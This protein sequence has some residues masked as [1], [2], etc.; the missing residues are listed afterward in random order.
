VILEFLDIDEL[1][2][3]V[4]LDPSRGL[5]ILSRMSSLI[6][7][8]YDCA[9]SSI[10]VELTE[11]LPVRIDAA[12][13]KL[14][15]RNQLVQL[16]ARRIGNGS[17]DGFDYVVV[18]RSDG[19]LCLRDSD[20]EYRYEIYLAPIEQNVDIVSRCSYLITNIL[21]FSSHMSFEVRF[22]VYELLNNSLEHGVGKRADKWMQVILEKRGNK[23]LTAIVDKGVE[24][25]PT[26]ESHF[27]LGSY[28]RSGKRRGLGLILTR[29]IAERMH[30]IRESGYNKVFFEKS[31]SA[32]S[33]NPIREKEGEMAQFVIGEPKVLRDGMYLFRLEGD[34]DTKGA[35]IMED[36]MSHLLEDRRLQVT[37]DF[38]K[39]PFISSAGVGVLLGLVSSIREE[40][41][42][43][44]F[45]NL[46][47]K[48]RSVFRLLNLDDY[49]K[50]VEA[51]E[52]FMS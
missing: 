1:A 26:G 36:L 25:D 9:V 33:D 52:S 6:M 37:L 21:G 29:R 13:K 17:Q 3:R 28:L 44:S 30:Y 14:V 41:G 32:M 47:P 5:K 34:L 43:V 24:F 2:I 12:L 27:D 8:A 39:V 10:V 7:V 35:L 16:A 48:V 40:G 38:E 51:E 15:D 18:G 4:A 45:M 50:I 23:L 46:S 11:E 31:S 22:S 20:N 42:E 49:F 19:V